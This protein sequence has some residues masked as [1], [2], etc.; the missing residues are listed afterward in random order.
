MTFAR[1]IKEELVHLKT[2]NQ[3]KLAELASLIQLNGELVINNDGQHIIFKSVNHAIT[4]HFFKLVKELYGS[5]MEII[6]RETS[7]KK[8]ELNVIIL[9]NVQVIA[10]ELGLLSEGTYEYELLT[11]SVKAKQ[12]YL[13]G[14]FLASG[15]IN[16]PVT[17]NYHLEIYTGSK[18]TIVFIQQVANSFNLN[19]KITKR[20]NGYILYL[21][22]AEAISEFLKIIG[23][24]EGVFKYED[25]RIQRDFANSINRVINCEIANEKKTLAAA[26]EQLKQIEFIKKHQNL[27]LLDK[28]LRDV[29]ILREE[30]PNSS[31]NELSRA[32]E[33]KTGE[34]ISKSGINHRLQKIKDLAIEIAENL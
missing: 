21:K 13:R 6:Y 17:A 8:K 28:S 9:T 31:L 3:E 32:Y 23:A 19:S 26:N 10:L 25:L 18:E 30:N 7:F 14:A 1:S 29:I 24:Y 16:D 22:E 12:A 33:E 15:S 5:E 34:T 20:R 11:Q 27:D 2:D 4:R